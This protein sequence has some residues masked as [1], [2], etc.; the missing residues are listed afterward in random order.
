MG[1]ARKSTNFDNTDFLN[2]YSILNLKGLRWD[3][4]TYTVVQLNGD[5][6][7]HE[8]RGKI[9]SVMWDLRRQY[10][11]LCRGYGFVIDVD[12]VTVAIPQGWNIPR[13]GDFNGYRV[14]RDDKFNATA[15]NPNHQAIVA[16]ILRESI[17][18]HFKNPPSDELGTLWQD[19]NDF[20]QMPD[21]MNSD[22]GIIYC[23]KFHVSPELLEGG[24]WVLQIAITTKSLDGLTVADYYRSGEVRQLAEMIQ[25]KRE[26]RLTRQNTP[27]EIR[28][29]RSQ[30]DAQAIVIELDNPD[31][32]IAH[33]KLDPIDQV[34]RVD[35]TILCKQYKKRPVPVPLSEIRLIP[36]AQIAQER[37]RETIIAPNERTGWYGKLRDFFNGM[38]AY[39]K[40]INLAEAPVDV[41]QFFSIPFKPPSL[42]VKPSPKGVD[43]IPVPKDGLPQKLK[44][45]RRT[46]VD[47]IRR[48]GYLQQ[49]PINPLFAY[50]KNYGRAE[51]LKRKL[52]GLVTQQGLNFRFEKRCPYETVHDIKQEVERGK[53]DALFVVLPE[54]RHQKRSDTDT[55]EKLK[56]AISIPSQCIQPHNT[57]SRERVEQ[58]ILNLLVKHHWVP[59]APAD[60][61]YYNV[62][63]GFDVGGKSNN[64]VMVCVGYGFIQPSEGFTFLLK[65]VNVETRQVE[66][67]PADHL[68]SGLLSIFDD[69]FHDLKGA[70]IKEPD[71]NRALFFR[72]GELRGQGKHWNEK[73]AL[74]K[75]RKELRRREWIDDDAL[76]TAT[77]ISK[78]ASYWRVLSRNH[79]TI[80]N[81]TVGKC[82]FPFDDKN[83]A[84]I[85][86]TGEPYLSPQGTASPLLVRVQDIYRRANPEEALRDLFWETDMCFTKIDTGVKLPWVLHVANEG[87]LQ[88]S[89]AYQI[90]GIT[91]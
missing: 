85:C 30:G 91:V 11:E 40:T 89:K 2:A 53:Y 51:W 46:L 52:N 22:Q 79:D 29:W 50:H 12:P 82:F 3:V 75:L 19:Y 44:Q 38:D 42:R 31:E 90:T 77:E 16:G 63:I 68:Y 47:H 73:D 5:E 15:S 59:F 24:R 69:L 60:T 84:I 74:D 65:E 36:E 27:P 49:R 71:F 64:R 78:R 18:Q 23:R 8:D 33:A 9:K 43:L 88:L 14:V 21:L 32:I 41:Q 54:G 56:K 57:R 17:K 86:T 67:I 13:Q 10:K 55:H 37:H 4:A 25:L 28:V 7:E 20:C 1:K 6:T 76:W 45:R 58:C 61:F 66:P 81:P 35:Q 80:G 26:N 48:Y 72:D 83:S 39:G 87:A 62:H 34:A 70:G